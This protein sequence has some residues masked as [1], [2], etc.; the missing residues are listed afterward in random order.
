M[1][2][3]FGKEEYTHADIENL[4]QIGAE[5]SINLDFKA[6]D[7]LGNSDGKKNEIAKDVSS[8]ANSDGG[9]IIY[10]VAE[11]DYKADSITFINGNDFSKEWLEQVINSRIQKRIPNISI[12]PIRFNDEVSKTVYIVKIHQ[13]NSAPHISSDKRYYKRFNFQSVPMEEYEI[14]DLFN[15]KQRTDIEIGDILFIQGTSSSAAKQIRYVEYLLRF[16]V[17]NSGNSIEEK[18]K[19]EIYIPKYLT[20]TDIQSEIKDFKIRDEG[21]ITVYSIPNSSPIYQSE[22]TTVI[23]GR[24]R[25]NKRTLH[26]LETPG[27]RLKVF[28]SSGTKERTFNMMNILTFG[29]NPISAT[30]NLLRDQQWI[31][32]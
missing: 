28:Y 19:L 27:I 22:I 26:F 32:D 7:S 30:G 24:I 4:I 23:N 17:Y 21:D 15:R 31:E 8:F 12:I 18:F 3:F 16:Q 11:K 13:S 9:I 14:R 29:T 5:E 20:Q 25:I 1:K 2:D 10:G 6:A